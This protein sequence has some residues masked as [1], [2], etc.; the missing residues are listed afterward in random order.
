MKI[1]EISGKAQKETRRKSKAGE[2]LTDQESEVIARYSH[3]T[4]CCKLARPPKSAHL[5]TPL[6][7]THDF[8]FVSAEIRGKTRGKTEKEA[9]RK[10]RAGE[11]LTD[12]ESEYIARYSHQT[13]CCSLAFIDTSRTD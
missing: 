2:F 5:L 6:A 12:H 9:R 7:L 4:L 10:S 13:P 11:F 1:N 3:Q 8:L